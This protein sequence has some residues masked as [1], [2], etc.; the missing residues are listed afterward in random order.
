MREGKKDL[1]PYI[2]GMTDKLAKI[3]KKGNITVIFSPP[4]TIRKMMDSAKDSMNSKFYKGVYTIPC[5]CGKVYIRET[6][7]TFHIRLKEHGVDLI[8]NKVQRSALAKHCNDIIHLS[9]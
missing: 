2:E 3:L 6:S 4:N 9:V 5:S 1:P 8:Y 7:R